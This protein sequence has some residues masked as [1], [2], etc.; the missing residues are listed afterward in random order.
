MKR[1]VGAWGHRR[2][3]T[4]RADAQSVLAGLRPPEQFLRLMENHYQALREYAP[5]PYPGRVVL[6]R[7]RTRPLF[8]LHG[9]DLGWGALARG[10]LTV[11]PIPGNHETLL[12]EPRVG[13]LA[14]ALKEHIGRAVEV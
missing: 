2:P 14:A 11:I 3:E 1:A 4:G 10:G 9:Y 5:K 13:V 6:F 7:A 8:R 12:R